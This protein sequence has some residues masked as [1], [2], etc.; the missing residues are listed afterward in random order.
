M[1]KRRDCRVLEIPMDTLRLIEM[2]LASEIFLFDCTL[3]SISK[4]VKTLKL[5]LY[6]AY[7]N[8]SCYIYTCMK[9]DEMKMFRF[10]PRFISC[11]TRLLSTN[12]LRFCIN[13][14]S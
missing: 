4:L 12:M 6:N 10:M 14:Y 2:L 13:N 9:Y 3:S 5:S 11:K 8:I 7:P 1:H